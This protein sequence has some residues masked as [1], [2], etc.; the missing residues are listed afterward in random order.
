MMYVVLV[1]PSAQSDLHEIQTWWQKHRSAAQAHRWYYG[2]LKALLKLEKNPERM[3]LAPENGRWPFQVRQLT[4]GLSRRS[5]HR[6]LFT[7]RKDSVAVLRVQ[8][9]AQ[10]ELGA[11]DI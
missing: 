6:A 5:T 2:F 8:H 1:M 11:D 10:Q 3:P 9:L 7:I 4:F